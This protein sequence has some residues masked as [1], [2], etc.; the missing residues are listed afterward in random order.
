MWYTELLGRAAATPAPSPALS[1]ELASQNRGP[2]LFVVSVAFVVVAVVLV[3]L[4]IWLRHKT[5][6]LGAD[7]IF[8][9]VAAVSRPVHEHRGVDCTF[10]ES[11][12]LFVDRFYH[13]VCCYLPRYASK[14]VLVYKYSDFLTLHVAIHFG[15]GKRFKTL[16]PDARV[17]SL[18]VSLK[19]MYIRSTWLTVILN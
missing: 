9:I 17:N 10:C 5:Q 2:E 14:R 7:D 12:I 1:P 19:R 4:R 11:L 13:S 16:E 15:F 18:L 3:G 6:T 8:I